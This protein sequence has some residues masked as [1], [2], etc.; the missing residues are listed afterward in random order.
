MEAVRSSEVRSSEARSSQA[1]LADETL[2]SAE[3]HSDAS[4]APQLAAPLV[5]SSVEQPWTSVAQA[6]FCPPTEQHA[7]W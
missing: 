5:H 3:A 6:D 4:L 2:S 7:R 1:L